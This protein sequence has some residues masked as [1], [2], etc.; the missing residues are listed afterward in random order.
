MMAARTTIAGAAL[1]LAVAS[2]CDDSL[3]VAHESAEG[4]GGTT[5]GG[6]VRSGD[7]AL[8]ATMTTDGGD[9]SGEESA[10][11][12]DATLQ[13]GSSVGT[14]A[15]VDA[16]AAADSP[17]GASDGGHPDASVRDAGLILGSDG[18]LL[19]SSATCAGTCQLD[20]R[21][22]EVLAS[23][24][25]TP[26]GIALDSQYVYWTN[27]GADS[28]SG[29]VMRTL[30]TGVMDGGTPTILAGGQNYP[31]AIVV[32]AENVYWTDGN[33]QTVMRRALDGGVPT[34]LASVQDLP[35]ALVED[36]SGQNLYWVNGGGSIA[37]CATNSDGGKATLLGSGFS[38]V[39]VAVSAT[40]IFWTEY[41]MMGTGAAI[42]DQ[43]FSGTFGS[44]RNTTL[45][46][47]G[48]MNPWPGYVHSQA[49]ALDSTSVYWANAF[50]V[51]RVGQ[52]GG[53]PVTLASTPSSDLDATAL[54]VDGSYVYWVN[55]WAS[56]ANAGT[57][58]RV[59][60]GGGTVETIATSQ[61][62]PVG[63]AVDATS[64][65]WIN[66]GTQ[67]TVYTDGTVMKLT[68]K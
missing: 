40:N 3:V 28:M 62:S 30:K 22:L 8:D 60:I 57:I 48:G 35:M 27:E 58:M 50:S 15:S 41:G 51:F 31:I 4:G 65:Y 20:G 12:G 6:N 43:L 46:A 63:I 25:I 64:V 47:D 7:A 5:T 53:A 23:N 38:F 33:G 18:G 45:L 13:D 32:D 49:L 56:L 1:L 14:D 66:Q 44:V 29:T 17:S 9:A 59:P 26:N 36:P 19:C 55:S 52:D 39:G 67:K 21:C 54:A 37:S 24:Q 10:D 42:Y 16:G 61:Q 34:T 68:P 11:G 2:S